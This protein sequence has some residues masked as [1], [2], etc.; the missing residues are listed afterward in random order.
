MLDKFRALLIYRVLRFIFINIPRDV[1]MRTRGRCEIYRFHVNSL[2]KAS[3][4]KR[5]HL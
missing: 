2:V 3:R 5:Y 1:R 4:D